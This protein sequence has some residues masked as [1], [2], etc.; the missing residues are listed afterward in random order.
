MTAPFNPR[1]A[2]GGNR[3]PQLDE[4]EPPTQIRIIR[5]HINDW[6]ASTRGLTLEEDAFFLRFIIRCY[7]QM[8]PLI[9]DPRR[10]SL[11]MGV[12]ITTYRKLMGRLIEL[13]KI[14]VDDGGRLSHPRAIREIEM[15]LAEYK[16]RSQAQAVRRE[17]ERN[18][19]NTT[20]E[21]ETE[22]DAKSDRNRPE[23]GSKSAFIERRFSRKC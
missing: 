19:A 11:A 10:N 15:Y 7:D 21:N 13:G 12:H 16:R 18:E 4:G 2:I 14:R 6:V 1:V 5:L 3:G 23:I 20:I 17:A 8:G 9:D 22:I